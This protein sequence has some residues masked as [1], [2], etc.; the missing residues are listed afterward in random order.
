MSMSTNVV[1][2]RPADEK[3]KQM[4]AIYDACNEAGVTR[5]KEVDAFFNGVAPDENGVEVEIDQ[6]VRKWCDYSCEGLEVDISKLPK[7]IKI[8]RFYN[9]W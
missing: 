4:K 1:A 5:P 6:A 8:V 2:F 3:W 9:S 7:D